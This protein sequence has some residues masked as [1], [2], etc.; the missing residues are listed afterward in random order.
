M[1]NDQGTEQVTE[2]PLYECPH[3][4]RVVVRTTREHLGW[5][6]GEAG[7][8]CTGHNHDSAHAGCAYPQ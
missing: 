3:V 7:S 8:Q 6:Y 2:R 4:R 5:Q 1:K